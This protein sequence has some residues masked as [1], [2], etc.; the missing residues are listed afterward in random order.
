M[1]GV[2]DLAPIL[3][4]SSNTHSATVANRGAA[5]MAICR[6]QASLLS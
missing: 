6:A 2:R 3:Y 4:N 1:I 5:T